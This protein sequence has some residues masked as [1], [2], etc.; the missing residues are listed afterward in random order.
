MDYGV[1]YSDALGLLVHPQQTASQ[2]RACR[3]HRSNATFSSLQFSV[4]QRSTRCPDSCTARATPKDHNIQLK[5]SSNGANNPSMRLLFRND[6]VY[7]TRIAGSQERQHPKVTDSLYRL[8]SLG[9]LQRTTGSHRSS[10]EL[11]TR[12][13]VSKSRLFYRSRA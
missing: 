13:C 7:V 2:Q 9:E 4:S 12:N 1:L 6:G 10:V 3:L 5:T 11:H 8:A